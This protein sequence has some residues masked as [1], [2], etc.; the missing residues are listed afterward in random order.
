M[1]YTEIEAARKPMRLHGIS[2]KSIDDVCNDLG[3]IFLSSCTK[4]QPMMFTM[5]YPDEGIS[6]NTEKGKD[7]ED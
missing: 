3:D 2:F 5:P 6:E 1:T 7:H 4:I